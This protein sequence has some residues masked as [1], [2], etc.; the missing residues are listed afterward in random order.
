MKPFIYT[1][2]R[3]VGIGTRATKEV[4]I[5]AETDSAYNEAFQVYEL[6]NKQDES[7][8]FS[9]GAKN[10]EYYDED[11]LMLGLRFKVNGKYFKNGI[12]RIELNLNHL[13]IDF[14]KYRIK[15]GE[16][17]LSSEKMF[18]AI[19][20]NEIIEVLKWVDGEGSY[21]ESPEEIKANI[22]NWYNG[23]VSMS[24]DHIGF[25]KNTTKIINPQELIDAVN[26]LRKVDLKFRIPI[27]KECFVVHKSGA[28]AKVIKYNSLNE[29]HIKYLDLKM[30]L[31]HSIVKE[32]D[33]LFSW[34]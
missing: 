28:I 23:L 21:F 32:I 7:F 12:V 34:K 19:P 16:E 10:F 18:R 2:A 5:K 25:L 33:L 15:D 27:Q 11:D 29:L 13:D 3:V 9:V 22:Q 14:Y 1:S 30:N 31:E 8:L 20:F 4:L 26:A 17:Y 24:L 6:I